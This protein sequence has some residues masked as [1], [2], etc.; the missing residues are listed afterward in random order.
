MTAIIGAGLSGLI[1]AI[2]FPQSQVFEANGPDSVQHRAVL[3]FRTDKLS[4]LTGIPFRRVTVR[5]SIV[6]AGKH[7][8]PTID[9]ANNYSRKTNGGYLDRSIWNIDPV[10]RFIAPEDIQPQMAELVGNRIV[11]NQPLFVEEIAANDQPL[12]STMPMV[13]LGKM[14]GDDYNPPEIK[15]ESAPIRVNRYRIAGANVYQ[16]IY[17]PDAD[18][19]IYRASMTGSMLIVESM[20]GGNAD[21]GFVASDG[22]DRVC[23]AFGIRPSD[24][25]S[26]EGVHHQRFGKISPIDESFRRSFIYNATVRHHIY[27]LGR[28]ATWR[29]ILLDDVVDDAAIIKRLIHEGHYGSTLQHFKSNKE[30]K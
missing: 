30:P 11:W 22:W 4:R 19:A 7:C 15:F 3:R 6:S 26:I 28:F 23:S 24:L 21:D 17:F 8:L 9:L 18:T 14:L 16:T 5:K 2:Q 20:F 25:E 29:N 13:I 12:I 10:E 27:S 1:A